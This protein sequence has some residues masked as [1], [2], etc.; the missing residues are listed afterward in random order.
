MVSKQI[1]KAKK[2]FLLSAE[3][4]WLSQDNSTRENF[5]VGDTTNGDYRELNLSGD[6]PSY[7]EERYI[8]YT[9]NE[10][11]SFLIDY[12]TA[13]LFSD[14]KFSGPGKD[15]V[16][17]FFD[18]VCPDG[19]EQ[20]VM[21]GLEAIRDGTGFIYKIKDKGGKL[22]QIKYFP[23]WDMKMKWEHMRPVT[24]EEGNEINWGDGLSDY[25]DANASE[26]EMR[27]IK[28]W[29]EETGSEWWFRNYPRYSEEDYKNPYMAILRLKQ[30]HL[31]PYGVPIGKS[32]FH[33]IKALKGVNRD[34]VAAIKKVAS[35]ILVVRY[36]TSAYND[37]EKETAL[38]NMGDSLKGLES[39]T[40]DVIVMDSSHDI[41]YLSNLENH[42][43]GYDG[44]L[45]NIMEHIEPVLS[46][47]L[48][49]Y[50]VAL[51]IVEQTGANK[52]LIARQIS[53][54]R[55]MLNQ[56]R[57]IVTRLIKTQ[58]L[59]DI[60]DK[61]VDV[62]FETAFDPEYIVLMYQAGMVSREWAQEN[63]DISDNGETFNEVN[64]LQNGKSGDSNDD[65][66]SGKREESQSDPTASG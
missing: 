34:I 5:D 32:C 30:S 39:A 50:L 62:I 63:L 22:S 33:S 44:R 20:I 66:M 47:V 37:S 16:D 46:S 17:R 8:E 28:V 40:A 14:I 51:G 9:E 65:G 45:L 52:S 29:N 18:T 61:D 60:T 23:T 10:W 27:W 25:D 36:D 49:N 19:L 43:G 56:Y 4:G 3:A 15:D 24:D 41:G 58:I 38:K 1:P 11:Y 31:T 21:A 64:N 55:K 26:G 7:Y 6:E 35:N 2:I 13:S 59:S 12:L 54:G 48:L 42:S 57:S 53:E